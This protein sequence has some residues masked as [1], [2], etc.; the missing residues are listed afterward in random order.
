[1]ATLDVMPGNGN[2]DDVADP[3]DRDRTVSEDEVRDMEQVALGSGHPVDLSAEEIE[4]HRADS[5]DES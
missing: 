5:D 1:M 3:S 4:E 2:Q